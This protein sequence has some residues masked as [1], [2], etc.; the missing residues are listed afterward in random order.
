MLGPEARLY[1]LK[2][3]ILTRI[4][5]FYLKSTEEI[6][7]DGLCDM[8]LFFFDNLNPEIGVQSNTKKARSEPTQQ[9]EDWKKLKE[10]NQGLDS[11]HIWEI[12][13]IC[14]RSCQIGDEKDHPTFF[15]EVRYKELE[16]S[17]LQLCS[18]DN[19]GF[20]S[21]LESWDSTLATKFCAEFIHH[22]MLSV[23][24]LESRIFNLC[25]SELKEKDIDLLEPYLQLLQDYLLWPDDHLQERI[26]EGLKGYLT[27]L[28]EN[29]EYYEYMKH[30]LTF[31]IKLWNSSK[32]VTEWMTQNVQEWEWLIQWLHNE[33][34]VHQHSVE[35]KASFRYF[36]ERLEQMKGGDTTLYD[37][38]I[39]YSSKTYRQKSYIGK[40]Y[41]YFVPSK[42]WTTWEV[43]SCLD[44]MV[45]I[46]YLYDA[47][48]E[49]ELWVASE[50]LDLVP[51]NSAQKRHDIV[52]ISEYKE[53]IEELENPN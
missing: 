45:L 2:V 51:Y 24:G 3:K 33:V 9:W 15:D 44:E 52:K 23:A 6:I 43:V 1:L 22:A 27:V 21:I 17:D 34:I 25:I 13:S 36:S 30:F 50:E 11:T 32:P 47:Q 38:D 53:M 10:D 19:E 29:T 28:K 40:N 5:N 46:K 8:K 41:D 26:S 18:L 39:V 16:E 48:K 12:M 7:N 20:M 42:G 31:L 35:M 49:K 14:F 4:S 37:E